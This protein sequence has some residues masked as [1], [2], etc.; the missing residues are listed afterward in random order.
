MK[1]QSYGYF[2]MLGIINV[3]NK[4]LPKPL[5]VSALN[6]LSGSAQE[7]QKLYDRVCSDMIAKAING[8]IIN[9]SLKTIRI[10]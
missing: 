8:S 4:V 1:H 10:H 2:G 3:R 9:L 6:N 7:V 5:I